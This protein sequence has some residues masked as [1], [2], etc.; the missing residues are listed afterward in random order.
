MVYLIALGAFALGIASYVTAGL[1]P[2]IELAFSISAS[3]WSVCTRQCG[4]RLINKFFLVTYFSSISRYWVRRLLSSWYC[5]SGYNIAIWTSKSHLYY[6]R[7]YGCRDG[8]RGGSGYCFRLALGLGISVLVG[9]VTWHYCLC[10]TVLAITH[11]AY[12]REY[13][14]TQKNVVTA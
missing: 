10:R 13:C 6:H 4:Q 14:A 11:I 7:W 2:I 1:I 8:L 12:F 5:G 9:Y 3:A